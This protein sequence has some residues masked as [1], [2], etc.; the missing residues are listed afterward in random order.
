[1]LLPILFLLTLSGA[2][3]TGVEV[4][5]IDLEMSDLGFSLYAVLFVCHMIATSDVGKKSEME[6]SANW[7]VTIEHQRLSSIRDYLC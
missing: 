5:R 7:C 4:H 3:H 6:V 1:M 2:V